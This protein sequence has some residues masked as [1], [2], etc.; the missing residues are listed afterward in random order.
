MEK[1]THRSICYFC[2]KMRIGGD[3]SERECLVGL[4]EERRRGWRKVKLIGLSLSFT[5]QCCPLL[6]ALRLPCGIGF[7]LASSSPLGTWPRT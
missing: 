5:P 3:E 6:Y 2:R 1:L 4:P 7:D